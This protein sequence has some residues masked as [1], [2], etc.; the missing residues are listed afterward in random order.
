MNLSYSNIDF[1]AGI[2]KGLDKCKSAPISND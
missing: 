1:R 2:Y